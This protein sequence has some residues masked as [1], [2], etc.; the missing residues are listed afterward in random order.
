MFIDTNDNNIKMM[1]LINHN[2]NGTN[3][4]TALCTDN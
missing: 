1:K 4:D 2:D 3:D